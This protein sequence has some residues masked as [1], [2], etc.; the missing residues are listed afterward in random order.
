MASFTTS[1]RGKDVLIDELQFMYHMNGWNKEGTKIYWECTV[2][3]QKCCP[4]RLHTKSKDY[5]YEILKHVNEH[6]HTS[7]KS[8]VDAK[9]AIQELKKDALT[10]SQPTRSL[11][12]DCFSSLD[13]CAR[14]KQKC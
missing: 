11:V 6:N 10:S 1:E 8:Q 2:R 12:A 5:D 4:A 9:V 7:T 3:K 14:S 13:D